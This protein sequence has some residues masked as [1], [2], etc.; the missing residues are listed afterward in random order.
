[1]KNI[2]LETLHN[3]TSAGDRRGSVPSFASEEQ[4]ENNSNGGNNPRQSPA[5]PADYRA[6]AQAAMDGFYARQR[7]LAEK[8]AARASK[9]KKAR[10]PNAAPLERDEQ[11]TVVLWLRQHGI[12]FA[13]NLEGTFR[14]GGAQGA[15]RGNMQRRAG[16]QPGRPDIEVF[17]RVPLSPE[18]RGVGL[19]LKRTKGGRLDPEQA[20]Y[21]RRLESCGWLC[22]VAYGAEDAIG[23]LRGL[24]Y[25]TRTGGTTAGRSRGQP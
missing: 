14:G 21:L 19:E 7:Q 8:E 15:I 23:W 13:A 3:D 5:S 17:T 18:A 22:H 9:P 11:R 10:D 24:G 2:E 6:R 4:K 1:M 20:A 16:M 25:G 12:E